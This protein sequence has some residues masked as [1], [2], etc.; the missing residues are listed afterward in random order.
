MKQTLT[1]ELLDDC[2]FS[3]RSATEGGHESLDRIPGASLLGAA[4]AKLYAKLDRTQ[5][6]AAFHSGRLRFGDGLPWNGQ[7]IAY[8]MPLCWYH[9]KMQKPE[10][11]GYLQQEH[12]YNL[13]HRAELSSGAQ[14]KQLRSGY[15]H[16]DGRWV[17]PEHSLRLKTA[18]DPATGCAAKGQ[19]FG[20]D[21]LARGQC[22]AA[23]IE[24]DD[25]FDPALFQQIGDALS[26][27][28]LLGRSR[29]AEY[30]RVR[31]T[32]LDHSP[33]PT[34][35]KTDGDTLT[36]WLLSDLALVDAHG[37]PT[38]TPSG[39]ALGL[40]GAEVDWDKTSL[41]QRR[42]SPWNAAR[43]GYDSERLILS[44]GGVITLKTNSA[45]DPDALARLQQG[46]GRY[47]EAGLGK[48]WVSPP[49]L[50]GEHPSFTAPVPPSKA[51][52]TK[53]QHPLL[54]WLYE[55]AAIDWRAEAE[56]QANKLAE[57][58]KERIQAGRHLL[59]IPDDLPF[60]PSKAQWSRI[61][62]AAKKHNGQ[63][64][65]NK[66]FGKDDNDKSAIIKPKGEGWQEEIIDNQDKILSI[67]TWLQEQLKF[68]GQQTTPKAHAHMIR[69]LARRVQD[70]IDRRTL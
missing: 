15:V 8:P 44:A 68:D 59:G 69:H 37:Q 49:L 29:S 43:H 60:G 21:A 55:R 52:S 9:A 11:K 24:A 38:L 39:E 70:D 32:K 62:T 40:P 7:E 47:R 35:Q 65:Y 67:G 23:T 5:A 64:L 45:P 26:G 25:D 1:I 63:D 33:E 19:L 53:P 66:L 50:H 46:I 4:A 18:I 2:V 36:L 13:F 6:F 28:T 3:A 20:Y 54:D 57:D 30:G 16:S 48:V 42:Y 27:E 41:R 14:P 56:Q 51:A 58:Y 31:I 34:S 12:V 17:K 10:E 22:F 61:G